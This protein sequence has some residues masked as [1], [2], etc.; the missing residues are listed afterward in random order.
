MAAPARI[1][2]QVPA[3]RLE[4]SRPQSILSGGKTITG[5]LFLENLARINFQARENRRLKHVAFADF[6]NRFLG[7][8]GETVDE[9]LPRFRIDD[10]HLLH[11]G[12]RISAAFDFEI[13]LGG[14]REQDL[15]DQIRRSFGTGFR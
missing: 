15:D 1:R 14:F 12:A 13:K 5:A 7:I 8:F 9:D 11:S 2:R 3:D 6:D 4:R 10:P